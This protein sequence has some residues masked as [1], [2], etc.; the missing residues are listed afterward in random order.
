[1]WDWFGGNERDRNNPPEPGTTGS[2]W[3]SDVGSQGPSAWA[4]STTFLG[5][6]AGSWVR[7]TVAGIQISTLIWEA[8]I[9]NSSN[10]YA[11]TPA[12]K[13]VLLCMVSFM[14]IYML[15]VGF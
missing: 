10:H 7:N 14:A 11:K 12:S 15:L 4:F 13:N 3:I 9:A 1:M 5:A 6:L 8:G 2:T